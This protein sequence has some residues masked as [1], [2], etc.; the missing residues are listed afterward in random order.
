MTGFLKQLKETAEKSLE[1]G[2][3]LGT[4]G[5]D[6][7]MEAAKKGYGN[8]R[9]GTMSDEQSSLKSKEGSPSQDSIKQ[10]IEK[11]SEAVGKNE[12]QTIDPEALMVLKLRLV[13]GEI[14]KEQ[15]EEMKN[16]LE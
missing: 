9:D 1:K 8:A 5:Y 4:K 10:N 12:S 2:V 16:T 13:K 3:E 15:F 14:T 7:A 6:T 11:S